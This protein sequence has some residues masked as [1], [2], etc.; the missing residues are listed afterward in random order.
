MEHLQSCASKAKEQI[1]WLL[2]LEERPRTLHDHYFQ[3][4]KTK[5][6]G[7]Y[8]ASR[9]TYEHGP[10]AKALYESIPSPAEFQRANHA[11]ARHTKNAIAQLAEMNLPVNP[12][13]LLKLLPND[14]LEPALQIMATVRAYFQGTHSFLDC[15]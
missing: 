5:F 14:P 13:D 4:Y 9:L 11:F 10:L 15:R 1:H 7:L 2:K 6:L 8:R 3:D 12:I